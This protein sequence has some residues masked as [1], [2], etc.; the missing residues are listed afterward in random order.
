VTVWTDKTISIVLVSPFSLTFSPHEYAKERKQTDNNKYCN[1][2]W[3]GNCMYKTRRPYVKLPGVLEIL[4]EGA[5]FRLGKDIHDTMGDP[6]LELGM[7]TVPN[8]E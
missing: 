2:H 1:A 3:D 7:V 6:I 5:I 4:D 8:N